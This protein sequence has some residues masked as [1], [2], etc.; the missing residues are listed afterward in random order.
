VNA[1]GLQRVEV[2][3]CELRVPN[4]GDHTCVGLA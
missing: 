3:P 1:E 4:E 2:P